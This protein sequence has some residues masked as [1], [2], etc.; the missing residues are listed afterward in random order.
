MKRRPLPSPL[1][2]I[3]ALSLAGC[4]ALSNC[5]PESTDAP[6][7]EPE[8]SSILRIDGSNGVRPLAAALVEAFEKA[9]PEFT[10][11]LGEGMG[12]SK[13]LDALAGGEIDIAT[14][15][16]G[17]EA[18]DLAERELVPLRF[19]RMAIVFAV[20]DSVQGIESLDIGQLKTIY[21]VDGGNW[22]DFGGSPGPIRKLM[23]PDFEVDAEKLRE[24]PEIGDAA[25]SPDTR[26]I[27]SSG[28]LA[29]ALNSTENS[30]GITTLSRADANE[31]IR[32]IAFNGIEPNEANLNSGS[33]PLSRDSYLVV[34]ETRSPAVEQFLAFLETEP[35]KG[36]LRNSSAIPVP[37]KE[38]L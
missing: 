28:D 15:S 38:G 20:H 31:H 33:Y 35:A 16:H 25:W 22:E 29:R 19:A 23:R 5:A 21:T 8:S 18:G 27:E 32:P 17:L 10:V 26:I 4:L 37:V 12:S 14:A 11:K 13:R 36:S 6:R 7:S 1:A 9:H 24:L 3:A 2:E 30:I 34:R